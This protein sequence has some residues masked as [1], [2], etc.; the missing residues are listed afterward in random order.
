MAIER[1]K[2]VAEQ[3]N[4]L[5]RE[6]IRDNTYAPG[7]RLPSESDLAL[8]FRV[9]RASIRTVLAQLAIEGLILRKQGDGTYVNERLPE[10]NTHLGGLWEFTRLIES[11]GYQVSIQAISSSTRLASVQE[12]RVLDLDSNSEVI[13]MDRI[14]F[15]DNRP[16]ILAQN[17]L[18]LTTLKQPRSAIDGNMPIKAFVKNYCDREIAFAISDIRATLA[19]KTIVDNLELEINSPLLKLKMTFYDRDNIPLLFGTSYLDDTVLNLR[20]VQAWG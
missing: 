8:E 20:L 6:R 14:F 16:V 17:V 13:S 2:T 9:S 1:P 11:S 15:A 7:Q 5:L 19:T 10:V 3:V 12:A 18:P 4:T